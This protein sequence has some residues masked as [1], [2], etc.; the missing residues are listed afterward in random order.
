VKTRV[1]VLQLPTANEAARP[2]PRYPW[3]TQI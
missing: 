1:V 2:H 3:K